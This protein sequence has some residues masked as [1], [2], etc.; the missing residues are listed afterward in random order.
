MGLGNMAAGVA[1]EAAQKQIELQQKLKGRTPE[2]QAII[3][4]FY[5][6]GGCLS[7]GLSDDEYEEKVM[8]RI[9]GIDFKQKGLD[10]LGVD[11]SEVKEIEPVHFEGYRFIDKALE[12]PSDDFNRWFS[13]VYQITWLYF[14]ETQVY[15]YQYTFHMDTDEKKEKTEE[16]FYKDITNFTAVNDSDERLVMA[17]KNCMGQ[18]QWQRK[19]INYDKFSL[20]VPGERLDCSMFQNEYT[21][22]AIQAMKAK[23]REKKS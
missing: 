23:L 12:K 21:S 17:G 22:R 19:T 16:Y 10:K 4:Y 2:Q 1:N 7:K 20:V 6:A 8:R 11:E 3:K 5:G 14:S 15:V 18:P 9:K 13:S